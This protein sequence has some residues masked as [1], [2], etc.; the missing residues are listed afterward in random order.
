MCKTAIKTLQA[1][2]SSVPETRTSVS[3]VEHAHESLPRKLGRVVSI[4][5]MPTSNMSV[6]HQFSPCSMV[7]H[8]ILRLGKA[9]G[10]RVVHNKAFACALLCATAM[11]LIPKALS[12][13][14]HISGLRQAIGRK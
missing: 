1:L 5:L 4:A 8:T 13:W 10:I 14:G 12:I 2:C 3:Y 6:G 7:T 9:S 11:K